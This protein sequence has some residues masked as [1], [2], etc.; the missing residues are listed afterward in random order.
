MVTLPQM[1]GSAQSV[2]NYV[3]KTGKNIFWSKLIECRKENKKPTDKIRLIW[4]NIHR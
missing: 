3:A 1:E 2:H 4:S